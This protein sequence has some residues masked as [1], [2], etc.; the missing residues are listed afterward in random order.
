MG[1]LQSLFA[2][3]I[4]G[5]IYVGIILSCILTDSPIAMGW[6]FA[7]MAALGIYEYQTMV[8]AN[9]YALMLKIW[10]ALMG[11]L[12]LYIAYAAMSREVSDKGLL[13]ALLPYM[14]YYLFYTLGEIYRIKRQPFVEIAQAFFSHFYIAIPLAFMLLLTGK[15]YHIAEILGS[16]FAFPRTFWLLPIFVFVW[17]NDTGAYLVGSLIGKTK[18]IERV[19]PNKTIEGTIGGMAIA[20][21][22]GVGFY[23]LFP[24][25][26]TLFHWIMLAL[27]VA[28]FSTFGD[29]FESFLKRTYG[30]KDSGR[31]LPGH[32][33]I[34]DRIDSILFAAI[35]A[36]MYINLMIYFL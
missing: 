22:G 35:P 11:G 15:Q 6:V 29:L 30:F 14:A 19:S 28:I 25:I 27:L 2:R 21:L 17:L 36:Y 31:L 18:L 7:A 1:K 12:L 5:I 23:H 24:G 16:D 13:M 8:G 9:T 10:H 3:T 20:I 4:T 33:G 32:G 26:T 34:L